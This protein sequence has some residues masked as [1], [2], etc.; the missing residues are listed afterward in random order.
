MRKITH[1]FVTHPSSFLLLFLNLRIIILL[2]ICYENLFGSGLSRLG[3]VSPLDF[4]YK[5]NQKTYENA[6]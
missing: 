5:Y 4:K 3:V 2:L 6:A 1:K